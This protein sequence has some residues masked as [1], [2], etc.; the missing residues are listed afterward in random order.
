M[1]GRMRAPQVVDSAHEH[2]HARPAANVVLVG[3]LVS[4]KEIWALNLSFPYADPGPSIRAKGLAQGSLFRPP[5]V[6]ELKY[7]N[8]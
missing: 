7:R 3:A 4:K 8:S 5:I 2:W 6:K 1:A